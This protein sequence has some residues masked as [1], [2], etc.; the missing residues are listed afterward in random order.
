VVSPNGPVVVLVSV[1]LQVMHVYR[2]GV[3]VGRAAV[4]S[5]TKNHPTPS[6]VFTSRDFTILSN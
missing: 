4:S 3:L 2:N 6:G 1:P 5:G